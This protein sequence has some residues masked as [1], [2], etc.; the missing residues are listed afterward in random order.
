MFIK[1]EKLSPRRHNSLH[2]LTFQSENVITAGGSAGAFSEK[3]QV[4][5]R[6]KATVVSESKISSRKDNPVN[7]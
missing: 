7:T 2:L 1:D 3:S 6:R 5:N 4:L